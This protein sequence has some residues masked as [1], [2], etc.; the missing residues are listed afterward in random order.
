M[1]SLQFSP[2]VAHG[3]GLRRCDETDAS[4][5]NQHA[6]ASIKPEALLD[7]MLES[8]FVR[9]IAGEAITSPKR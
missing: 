7:R 5:V 3:G 2:I 6:S 4:I 9:E 1:G 8:R